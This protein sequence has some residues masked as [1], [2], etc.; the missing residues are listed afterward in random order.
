[1]EIPSFYRPFF[2][3]AVLLLF[4]KNFGINSNTHSYDFLEK[5]RRK[6][7][8]NLTKAADSKECHGRLFYSIA[9]GISLKENIEEKGFTDGRYVS[10][11][12]LEKVTLDINQ[13]QYN[14]TVKNPF[15]SYDELDNADYDD[16]KTNN[17]STVNNIKNVL[18]ITRKICF[19]ITEPFTAINKENIVRDGIP[20]RNYNENNTIELQA[21]SL[22]NL[23]YFNNEEL[24]YD[25]VNY[26][27]PERE[28]GY[29][30]YSYFPLKKEDYVQC[31]KDNFKTS[32]FLIDTT[33]PLS[34]SLSVTD[35]SPEGYEGDNNTI[36]MNYNGIRFYEE[37]NQD[38]DAYYTVEGNSSKGVRYFLLMVNNEKRHAAP[39]S[40]VDNI[41]RSI[42]DFSVSQLNNG[43]YSTPK[44]RYQGVHTNDYIKKSYCSYNG[45]QG[46]HTMVKIPND[47]DPK[48]LW[49][50]GDHACI[51]ITSVLK[52]C[53][54]LDTTTVVEEGVTERGIKHTCGNY[55]PVV[56]GLYDSYTSL[57]EDSYNT[58]K[59][60]GNAI[61]KPHTNR[62]SIIKFYRV[63]YI[64]GKE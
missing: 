13:G 9:N 24:E 46:I 45:W 14:L 1:M 32:D 38:K 62:F 37:I 33:E 36:S 16:I 15:R 25:G 55:R 8:D 47:G 35:A 61:I 29:K 31:F 39:K 57:D 41:L 51:D 11:N 54:G 44:I 48:F 3:N 17:A 52:R 12:V 19:G 26:K 40:E 56:I 5:V 18:D 21:Q 42:I 43:N 53:E 2:F 34:V 22:N 28:P 27:Y 4:P 50:T 58:E 7:T 63:N 6:G 23:E 49:G 59:K 20:I 64:E 60:N 10:Q 30:K